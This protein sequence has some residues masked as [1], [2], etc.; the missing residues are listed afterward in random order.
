MVSDLCDCDDIM[1]L[2]SDK[3][4]PTF[5]EYCELAKVNAFHLKTSYCYIIIMS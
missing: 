3:K 2:N 4:Y 5:V 1:Y